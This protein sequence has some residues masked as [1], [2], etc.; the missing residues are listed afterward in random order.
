MSKQTEVQR[1]IQHMDDEWPEDW[2]GNAIRAELRRLH[3]ENERRKA[4]IK[5]WL[6]ANA[7][8]GWIDELRTLNA[9]LLEALLSALPFVEDAADDEIYKSHRVHKVLKEIRAAIEKAGAK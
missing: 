9:D 6:R 5:D 1:L 7:P 8:G 4:T 2:D 3:E